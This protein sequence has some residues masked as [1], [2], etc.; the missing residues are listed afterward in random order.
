MNLRTEVRQADVAVVRDLVSATGAFNDEEV[1]IAVELVEERLRRGAAS[2]YEFVFAENDGLTVGYVCYGR[3]SGTVSSHDLYW[4]VVA[5]GSQRH[6]VGGILLAECE[7]RSACEGGGRLY[8][9]TAGKPSYAPARSFY[10]RHGFHE[11]ARLEDF[12]APGDDKVIFA[13]DL[14]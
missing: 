6:G 7:R 11:V 5:P 2:G 13:K 8:V 3:V 10:L 9:D 1:A 14:W 12:Y 4:I